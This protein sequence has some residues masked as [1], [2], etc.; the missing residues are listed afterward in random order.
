M[1]I[2]M[3]AMVIV[4]LASMSIIMIRHLVLLYVWL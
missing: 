3:V 1:A 4:F 2:I